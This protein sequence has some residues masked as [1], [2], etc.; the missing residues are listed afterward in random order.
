MSADVLTDSAAWLAV[1]PALRYALAA[2]PPSSALALDLLRRLVRSARASCSGT[3]LA[4]LAAALAAHLSQSP[5]ADAAEALVEAEAAL[6]SCWQACALRLRVLYRGLRG[7]LPPQGLQADALAELATARIALLRI[8][9][10]LSAI[11]ADE[12]EPAAWPTAWVA[13]AP[14]CAAT[15]AALQQD[16]PAFAAL[17]A[18]AFAPTDAC[19]DDAGQAAAVRV[20]GT[21]LQAS[22]VRAL[23]PISLCS[24]TP[25]A[26]LTHCNADDGDALS[27]TLILRGFAY[28]A[29]G[30]HGASSE[31]AARSLALLASA[32]RGSEIV[33]ALDSACVNMLASPLLHRNDD[34][35]SKRVSAVFAAV[36]ESGDSGVAALCSALEGDRVENSSA[37]AVIATVVRDACIAGEAHAAMERFSRTLIAA[38]RCDAAVRATVLHTGLPAA[39]ADAYAAAEP[40]SAT[41][42]ASSLAMLAYTSRGAA[43]V[44]STP[45][46]AT[47]TAVALTAIADAQLAAAARDGEPWPGTAAWRDARYAA[48]TLGSLPI[49]A[50]AL[51]DSGWYAMLPSAASDASGIG[52]AGGIVGG[53]QMATF[54]AACTAVE[55]LLDDGDPAALVALRRDG[56][57]PAALLAALLARFADTSLWPDAEEYAAVAA[58]EGSATALVAYPAML[59]LGPLRGAAAKV[60]AGE[61]DASGG[62]GVLLPGLL[63]AASS[64]GFSAAGAAAAMQ[65]LREHPAMARFRAEATH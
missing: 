58:A 27:L 5:T 40:A 20:L 42:L 59:L 55:A 22:A 38:F 43:A 24:A 48:S 10:A 30:D 63:R 34:A 44:C 17:A 56:T 60:L 23:L 39:F 26:L 61:G 54:V 31:A 11:T 57:S 8:P 33:A 47:A 29:A 18:A 49:G 25:A 2:P 65:Q 35:A 3:Q 32:A 41:D 19:G 53:V 12:R 6:R 7:A 64:A 50:A 52:A 4:Q 36:A 9:G 14:A 21:L 62:A 51:R 45:G 1:C 28:L 46:G 15:A 13:V 16:A 37:L